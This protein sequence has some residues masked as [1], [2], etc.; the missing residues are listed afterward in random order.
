[1]RSVLL[2]AGLL[3]VL[4]LSSIAQDAP[5]AGFAL[6]TALSPGGGSFDASTTLSSGDVVVFDGQNVTQYTSD[7]AFLLTLGSLG[8]ATFPSFILADRDELAVYFGES[9]NGNIYRSFLGTSATP[10]FLATLAFNYDAAFGASGTLFVSAATCGFGCGNE[11]WRL[12]VGSHQTTLLA[13][14]PGASGPIAVDRGGNLDYGTVS[15]QFPPPP[16]ASSVIRFAHNLLDGSSVLD[17]GAAQL[18]GSG[19]DGAARFAYDRRGDALF[20]LEN[21]FGTGANRIRRVR[22]SAAQSPVLVEGEAF[23]SLGNP[24]FHAG[25]GRQRF[26]AY[27]PES[28]GVLSYVS[29]DFVSAP[30][31]SLLQPLR[32]GIGLAGPGTSGPGQFVLTLVD[33]PPSGFARVCYGPSARHHDPEAVFV[34]AGVPL[35]FVVDR[36]RS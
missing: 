27:Q 35:F 30:R 16:G 29:N 28:S 24:T 20:L 26:L 2:S 13:Q 8:A 5:A 23:R 31:R 11:I 14:V 9:S 7:G 3:S 21:D 6:Q 36:T 32:P 19:F 4:P 15:D 22:G 1:M 18:V 34:V 25:A 17:L 10:E 33:G 12:D